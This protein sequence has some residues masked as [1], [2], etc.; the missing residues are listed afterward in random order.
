MAA[1]LVMSLLALPWLTARHFAAFYRIHILCAGAAGVFVFMHGFGVVLAQH[2]LPT[3]LPGVF[4]WLLDLAV[5]GMTMNRAQPYT[6]DDGSCLLA[7]VP[8]A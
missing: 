5:R 4:L 1:L 6:L 2:R 8:F 3:V 7:S